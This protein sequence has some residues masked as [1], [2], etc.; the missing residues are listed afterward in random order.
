MPQLGFSRLP[1]E[2]EAICL[3]LR[4]VRE[5]LRLSQMEYAKRLGLTRDRLASY[6][7]ARAPVRW[8]LGA[9]LC[10]EFRRS[11]RWLARGELPKHGPWLVLQPCETPNPT[12]LFS[13]GYKKIAPGVLRAQEAAARAFN[14]PMEV[15][16]SLPDAQT[17]PSTLTEIAASYRGMVPELIAHDLRTIPDDLVPICC[18]KLIALLRHLRTQALDP[19]L[20]RKWRADL[21]EIER[22]SRKKPTPPPSSKPS[23]RRKKG[24]KSGASTNKK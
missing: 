17:K 9:K 3:R 16:D 6:E 7:Y 8:A 1:L 15:L 2:E 13:E 22:S 10:T 11:Q 19:K 23:V 4:E 20:A 24:G 12:E 14:I 18:Q 21:R 5:D